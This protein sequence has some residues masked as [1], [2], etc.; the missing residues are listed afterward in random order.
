MRW[1]VG[2]IALALVG[3][4]A[5]DMAFPSYTHRYRLTLTFE[6]NGKLA[7]GSSVLQTTSQ[8]QPRLGSIP[9]STLSLRGEA[10]F[11]DLGPAGH[12]IAILAQSRPQNPLSTGSIANLALEAFKL[13]ASCFEP[14]CTHKAIARASGTRELPSNFLPVLVYFEN[15]KDPSTLKLVPQG[16]PRSSLGASLTLREATVELTRQEVTWQ[17]HR[18]LP[19]TGDEGAERKANAALEIQS[20]VSTGHLGGRSVIRRN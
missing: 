11:V 12:I 8:A 5:W 15:L 3:Y 4:F 16:S 9:D 7:S 14:Q 17:I 19:W 2:L 6:V 1:L 18:Y 20:A 13:T 10:I